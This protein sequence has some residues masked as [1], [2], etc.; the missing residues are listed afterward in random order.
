[1]KKVIIRQ[2]TVPYSKKD[3]GSPSCKER[4]LGFHECDMSVEDSVTQREPDHE[5]A[6]EFILQESS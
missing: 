2:Q 3:N 1:V 5:L 6:Q 4:Y